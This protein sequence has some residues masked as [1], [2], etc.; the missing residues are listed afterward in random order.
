MLTQPPT[1]CSSGIRLAEPRQQGGLITEHTSTESPL[2]SHPGTSY[3]DSVCTETSTADSKED[4]ASDPNAVFAPEPDSE[5]HH[6]AD[7]AGTTIEYDDDGYPESDHI[8]TCSDTAEARRF[9]YL[10]GRRFHNEC[11]GYHW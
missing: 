5:A 1:L 8:S 10:F 11:Q 7:D 2:Q 6:Q 4:T 3:C 9:Q